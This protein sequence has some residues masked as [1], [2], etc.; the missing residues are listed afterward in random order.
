MLVL[1]LLAQVLG[2]GEKI[3]IKVSI[4]CVLIDT[5][6]LDPFPLQ[7]WGDAYGATSSGGHTQLSYTNRGYAELQHVLGDGLSSLHQ[8][9]VQSPGPSFNTAVIKFPPA[10]QHPYFYIGIYTAIAFSAGLVNIAGVITQVT[11]ALRASRILFDRLLRT[12]VRA[13]MRW[14]DVTPQGRMLNRFSKVS[15]NA[16]KFPKPASLD[17]P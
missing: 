6:A 9:V 15:F 10:Q 7:I 8:V 11:G 5:H 2:I 3:W 12:V 14:H 16:F 13:T 17:I 1:I 4:T